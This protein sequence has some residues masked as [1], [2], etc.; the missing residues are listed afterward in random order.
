[1]RGRRRRRR[2]VERL[3]DRGRLW[4]VQRPVPH[5]RTLQPALSVACEVFVRFCC[6]RF[7]VGGS[8]VVVAVVAVGGQFGLLLLVVGG[9]CGVAVQIYNIICV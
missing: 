9:A 2:R 8:H 1:M 4:R 7:W 3:I 6:C 5:E